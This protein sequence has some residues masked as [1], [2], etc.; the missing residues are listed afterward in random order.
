[1]NS[2]R[3]WSRSRVTKDLLQFQDTATAALVDVV[4]SDPQLLGD[5]LGGQFFDV[6]QF[7]YLAVFVVRDLADCPRDQLLGALLVPLVLD[8][9]ATAAA[10]VGVIGGER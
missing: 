9:V 4:H 3:I 1:M 8:G 5:L 10:Q 7:E 6:G 2:L